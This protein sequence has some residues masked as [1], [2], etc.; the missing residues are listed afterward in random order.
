ML[1][2]TGQAIKIWLNNVNT[3][4]FFNF[5]DYMLNVSVNCSVKRVSGSSVD[6]TFSAGDEK[7]EERCENCG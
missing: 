7:A 5:M 3:A 6:S 2:N 1:F 4:V